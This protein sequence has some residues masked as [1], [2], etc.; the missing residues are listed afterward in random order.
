MLLLRTVAAAA[1]AAAAAAVA[2]VAAAA[3]AAQGVIYQVA[4][5][6]SIDR[7]LPSGSLTTHKSFP[8]TTSTA[9]WWLLTCR[10]FQFARVAA[11]G[12]NA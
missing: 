7:L 6:G 12:R 9:Q 10:G 3:A 1:A 8:T 2:A 5:V 4:L 11:I